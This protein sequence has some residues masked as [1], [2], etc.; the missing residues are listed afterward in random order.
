MSEFN[1]LAEKSAEAAL[2]EMKKR[3]MFG[4][5]HIPGTGPARQTCGTCGHCSMRRQGHG[6]A[7]K[8]RRV[9]DHWTRS[10]KTDVSIKAPS[11]FRLVPQSADRP[12]LSEDDQAAVDVAQ[13]DALRRAAGRAK[14]KRRVTADAGLF[15]GGA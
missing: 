4:Y 15:G 9:I 13:E 8:C 1:N 12:G 2:R 14:R 5:A 6:Y 11:C 7:F 10:H 3:E